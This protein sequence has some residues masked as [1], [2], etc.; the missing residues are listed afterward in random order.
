MKRTFY[1]QY[2]WFPFYMGCLAFLF[3]LPYVG[4][5]FSNLDIK[6]LRELLAK[7]DAGTS[8]ETIVETYFNNDYNPT[9]RRRVYVLSN[10]LVKVLYLVVNVGCFLLTDWLFNGNFRDFGPAWMGWSE[11]DNHLQYE[12]AI[13]R[14]KT[15]GRC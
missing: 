10:L 5:R 15:Y 7:R 14:N 6:S 2:Q 12:Y 1:N 9:W 13:Y 4:F 11:L 3:Y 8:A